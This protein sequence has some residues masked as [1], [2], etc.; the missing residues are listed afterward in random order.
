MALALVAGGL[1]LSGVNRGDR[2][3]GGDSISD[4]SS[5]DPRGLEGVED[6]EWLRSD[7]YVGHKLDASGA[8]QLPLYVGAVV[9]RGGV[10]VTLEKVKRVGDNLVVGVEILKVSDFFRNSGWDVQP[11]L[12]VEYG[13]G[14]FGDRWRADRKGDG[15]RVPLLRINRLKLTAEI[16]SPMVLPENEDSWDEVMKGAKLWVKFVNQA[17]GVRISALRHLCMTDLKRN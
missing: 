10:K 8:I 15:I 7:Y 17:E 4:L 5:L 2:L 11:S 13:N 3:W 9:E 1:M 12:M 14:Y 6:W 16:F